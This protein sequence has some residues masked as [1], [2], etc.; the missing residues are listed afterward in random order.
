AP[1]IVLAI[2]ACFAFGA[3]LLYTGIRTELTPPEDRSVAIL[4]ISAPQ[5]VSLEYTSTQ[6]RQIEE[7]V[8]PYRASG[9]VLNVFSIAGSRGR[10]NSGFM[11]LTLA[12]WEERE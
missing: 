4:S 1:A 3:F 2:A 5:G 7:L 8:E 9:E 10:V 12:P 11:V 6:L